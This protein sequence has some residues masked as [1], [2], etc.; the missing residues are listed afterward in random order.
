[1]VTC[2]RVAVQRVE[3]EQ[4]PGGLGRDHGLDD[5]AHGELVVGDPQPGPVGDRA[6]V[7]RLAQQRVT[8]AATASAPRTHRKVSCSPANDAS[9]VSSAVALERTA[10]GTS[11]SPPSRR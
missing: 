2:E 10:T 4:H 11:P 5:H 9:A 3:G 1:M 8:W 7:N 6:G